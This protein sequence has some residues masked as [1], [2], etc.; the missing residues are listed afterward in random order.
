MAQDVNVI[1]WNA[2]TPH[3][4]A[5]GGDDGCLRVWDLRTLAAPVADFSYHRCSALQQV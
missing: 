3:T 4:L 1:S 2:L 5:S